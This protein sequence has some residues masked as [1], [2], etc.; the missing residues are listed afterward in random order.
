MVE[1]DLQCDSILEE[2]KAFSL[3]SSDAEICLPHFIE[4]ISSVYNSENFYPKFYKAVTQLETFCGLSEKCSTVVGFEL[5][6]HVLAYY[7]SR[8]SSV[9]ASSKEFHVDISEREVVVAVY[10]AICIWTIVPSN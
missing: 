9:C 3:T 2:L 4:V 10:I 8:S 6:N 7:K 1:E 5:A